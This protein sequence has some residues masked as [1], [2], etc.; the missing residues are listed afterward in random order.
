MNNGKVSSNF[1][2]EPASAEEGNGGRGRVRTAPPVS[3]SCLRACSCWHGLLTLGGL[4][5]YR[6]R[7]AVERRHSALLCLPASLPFSLNRHFCIDF[8]PKYMCKH[9]NRPE[10]KL[11][12]EFSSAF[13][14]F[15]SS[16]YSYPMLLKN[17]S[18]IGPY[19]C[20]QNVQTFEASMFELAIFYLQFNYLAK[21]V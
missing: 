9:L 1:S 21:A 10:A 17:L 16:P 18:N 7:L 11:K 12:R 14:V 6:W 15:N 4:E 20:I 3:S 19:H 5:F 2:G 8:S 13:L